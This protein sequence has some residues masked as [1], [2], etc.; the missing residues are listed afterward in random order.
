MIHET[1]MH[2]ATIMDCEGAYTDEERKMVYSVINANSERSVVTRVHKID[3][4][5]F[6]NCVRTQEIKGH[7]NQEERD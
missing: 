4:H 1:T 2:G 3:P 5:A 6:I 7:F